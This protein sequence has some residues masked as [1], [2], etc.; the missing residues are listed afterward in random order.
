[1]GYTLAVDSSS[2]VLS[3]AITDGTKVLGEVT[4]NIKKNHSLRLMP[5][6]EQ[7][8]KDVEVSPKELMKI[9]VAEGPGSYTGVRI[10]VTTAK[11]LAWALNIPLVGVSSLEML[12][13]TGRYF[14][15][16]IV[17]IVDAR[18]GQVFTTLYKNENQQM[19]EVEEDALRMLTVWL[20]R[21]RKLDGSILFI[22]QDLELHRDAICAALGEQAL[23]APNSMTLPRAGELAALGQERQMATSIHDFVPRYLRLAEAEAKWQNEQK[24]V[25]ESHD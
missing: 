23:F 16:F 1:M 15:G 21:L 3:V 25:S 22:G 8:M 13:Q 18:R 12:V 11:S 4:T 2:F 6:I 24:K 20:E 19:I 14:D 7:L 10:A 5:A 9:V 17:P